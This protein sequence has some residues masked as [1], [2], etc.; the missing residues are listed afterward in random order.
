M[1]FYESIKGEEEKSK[2]KTFDLADT[3]DFSPNK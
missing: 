2:K 1:Q 3:S